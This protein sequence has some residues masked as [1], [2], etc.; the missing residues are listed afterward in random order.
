MKEVF[1]QFPSSES[2]GV[3]T[4]IVDIKNCEVN[5]KQFTLM[6]RLSTS[7]IDLAIRTFNAIMLEFNT[8]QNC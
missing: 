7:D 1:L 8:N 4:H 5:Y 2:L 6:C 3:F